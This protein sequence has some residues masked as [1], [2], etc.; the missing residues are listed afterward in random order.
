MMVSVSKP[1]T[2]RDIAMRVTS[3]PFRFTPLH[4]A[5]VLTTVGIG[6]DG[7]GV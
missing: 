6:S 7:E 2:F 1:V 3:H 4:E 5:Y